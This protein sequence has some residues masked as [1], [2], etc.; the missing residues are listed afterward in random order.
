MQR[1]A[2]AAAHAL[3]VVCA[4]GASLIP[5]TAQTSTGIEREVREELRGERDLRR[6][7]VTV[8]GTEVTLTTGKLDT[9]WSKSEAIRWTLEVDGV[10]TVV[11]ELQ[12]F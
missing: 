10:E 12:T 8:R 1:H 9:F 2:P 3:L 7:D 4:F 6:L 11:S 5:A